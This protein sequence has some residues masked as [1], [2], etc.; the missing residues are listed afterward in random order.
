MP[1][2]GELLKQ[3]LKEQGY[4]VSSF[5]Q[6]ASLDRG[7]LYAIFSGKRKL[8]EP[9]LQK[10]L[11]GSF[12]TQENAEMLRKAYYQ[13]VYGKDQMDRILFLQHHFP[14]RQNPSAP[15]TEDS[16][17]QPSLPESGFLSTKEEL[18][19]ALRGLI[20]LT[21]QGKEAPKKLCTNLPYYFSQLDDILYQSLEE[22]RPSFWLYRILPLLENGS[23]T[24]NLEK[25][26]CSLRYLG[27]RARLWYYYASR[28]RLSL[29]DQFFPF[30]V[31]SSQGA[32]LIHQN[33]RQGMLVRQE[34]FC[35]KMLDSFQNA[36]KSCTEMTYAYGSALSFLSNSHEMRSMKYN[37]ELGNSLAVL[38]DQELLEKYGSPRFSGYS[39][40]GLIS[41][42]LSFLR[43]QSSSTPDNAMILSR[44]NLLYFLHSGRFPNIPREYLAP[45]SLEDRLEL[46]NRLRVHFQSHPQQSFGILD[47]RMLGEYRND[48]ALSLSPSNNSVIFCGQRY[49]ASARSFVGECGIKISNAVLYHDFLSFFD[50]ARRNGYIY[51]TEHSLAIVQELAFGV[52][53]TGAIPQPQPQEQSAPEQHPASWRDPA[54]AL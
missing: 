6:L 49:P 27:R 10:I 20:R 8:P 5:S 23:G 46:L 52:A 16:G 17:E 54:A 34:E 32:L 45:L 28:P 2:F 47:D 38:L 9:N 44:Q 11:A 31:V 19:Q 15:G 42:L 18:H 14:H 3:I 12:F 48:Y 30:Y 40:A 35:A 25:L 7:W 51:N 41:S 29:T 50:Y 21:Q 24:H 1:Q 53:Q 33:G 37:L 13:E 26:F 36:L 22:D 39:R 4:S 43:Q